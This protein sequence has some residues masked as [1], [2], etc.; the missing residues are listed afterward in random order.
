MTGFAISLLN[1]FV[2]NLLGQRKTVQLHLG[3]KVE[4]PA[5]CS[6]DRPTIEYDGPSTERCELA[7]KNQVFVYTVKK[8][9]GRSTRM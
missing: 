7:Q 1:H 3:R 2:I 4:A 8:I 5:E 6:H 9:F